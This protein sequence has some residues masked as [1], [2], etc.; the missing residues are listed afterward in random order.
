MVLTQHTMTMVG[1]R[2]GRASAGQHVREIRLERGITQ[3]QLAKMLGITQPMLSAY[4]TG[5]RSMPEDMLTK[6]AH[7]LG[8]SVDAL[9]ATEDEWPGTFEEIEGQLDEG[10]A[11]LKSA[12]IKLIVARQERDGQ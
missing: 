4:E 11:T 5:R 1:R 7:S 12:I 10:F 3:V 8:V 9:A 6:I 2:A